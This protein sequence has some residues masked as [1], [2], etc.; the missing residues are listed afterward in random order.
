MIT[1]C[2]REALDEGVLLLEFGA[3]LILMFCIKRI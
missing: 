2:A 3:V 1:Q